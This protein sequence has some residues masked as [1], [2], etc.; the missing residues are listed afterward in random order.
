MLHPRRTLQYPTQK[1]HSLL[2]ACNPGY[3]SPGL[4]PLADIAIPQLDRSPVAPPEAR[5]RHRSA[6]YASTAAASLAFVP[7]IIPL[8]PSEGHHASTVHDGT[9]MVICDLPPV[10]NPNAVAPFVVLPILA[11]G[12]CAT[13][14]EPFP[15]IRSGQRR[16]ARVMIAS[17]ELV[18]EAAFIRV[19]TG[20]MS[21]TSA[22]RSGVGTGGWS[23][24]DPGMIGQRMIGACLGGGS[25]PARRSIATRPL[26][27]WRLP[28]VCAGREAGRPPATA[29]GE[30]GR[31]VGHR[32]Q[33]TKGKAR[34]P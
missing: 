24:S 33:G 15:H 7:T 4:A 23:V 34:C 19:P 20:T 31:H 10:A 3:G 5:A 14:R 12:S 27:S 11:F 28:S 6:K 1:S 22:R 30:R 18:P 17:G 16:V 21:W 29:P 32:W 26:M 8:S 2:T 13:I 9:C 25:G